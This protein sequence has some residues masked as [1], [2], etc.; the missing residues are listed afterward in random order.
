M[1]A[2][3][4]DWL[5]LDRARLRR[6]FDRAAATYDEAAVL[7]REIGQRMA[8]RLGVI[9][10]EPA[11]ILD[12]GCGTGEAIGELLTRYPQAMIVGL[13]LALQMAMA[14]RNRAVAASG[15]VRSRLG[16]MLDTFIP[17]RG[18]PPR[19]VCGDA[20]LL[21]LRT[22]SV[23]LVWSNL[24]LQWLNEPHLAIVEF[25]RVLKVGGL[26]SFTTFG[27]DTLMELREAFADV[28]GQTHVSRFV[29]MHDIGDMLVDAG[30][31]DPV[32][33]MEKITVTYS[34]VTALMRDL[35]AIGA[36]NATAGRPRGL[37]GRHHWQRVVVAM[38]RFRQE[39]RLPA[40]FEVIY[41]HAWKTAAKTTP[42]GHAVIQFKR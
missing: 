2:E 41:G 42:E 18:E 8:E 29:D 31:A 32:M 24:A 34:D 23:D 33:D 39:G 27:P 1:T 36:R 3:R 16:R 40:T 37:M 7:Q 28:D 38:D 5:R 4:Q 6:S 11:T 17:A 30:F 9:R 20:A 10:L 26:A 22:A 12:I 35:K 14:A 15:G 13:D 25:H 21:P 19:F